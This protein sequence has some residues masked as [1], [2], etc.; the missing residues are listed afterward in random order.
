MAKIYLGKIV[1]THGIKG[2]LKL[3]SD[4]DKKEKVYVKD[5]PLD[6]DD[7][8]YKL[9]SFR[10]HKQ[11]ELILLDDFNNI[12]D[13]LFLVGKS[14]YINSEDL[15]LK[16]NEYL[17]SDLIE[18]KVLEDDECLG[19]VKEIIRSK[20]YEILR[21]KDGNKEFLVPLIDN[22]VE[23]FVKDKKIIYTKGARD[24]KNLL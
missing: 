1:S 3:L 21:I 14:V 9:T 2:E 23:A 11:Y 13:V 16:E 8:I 5:F 12:N 7:K 6:I 24:L 18:A 20:Q 17:L 19:T 10:P 22:Y 4:F 15:D